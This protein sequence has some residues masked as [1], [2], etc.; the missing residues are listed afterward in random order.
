MYKLRESRNE[1]WEKARNLEKAESRLRKGTGVGL[2]FIET[3]FAGRELLKPSPGQG[4]VTAE[5]SPGLMRARR[6][7]SL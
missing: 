6:I 5:S 2:S 1:K 3:T 7:L 4:Q